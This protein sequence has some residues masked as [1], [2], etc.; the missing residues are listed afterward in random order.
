MESNEVR[1]EIMI[2]EATDSRSLTMK[3]SSMSEAEAA[4]TALPART[5]GDE[6][7]QQIPAVHNVDGAHPRDDDAFLGVDS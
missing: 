3:H 2:V 6:I 7:R 5:L 1:R 4:T